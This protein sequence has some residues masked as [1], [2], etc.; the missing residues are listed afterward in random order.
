MLCRAPTVGG[1]T[2][3]APGPI[4]DSVSVVIFFICGCL[5]VAFMA[6]LFYDFLTIYDV[7]AFRQVLCGRAVAGV[8]GLSNLHS[9]EVEDS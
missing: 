8:A 1:V 9:A 6:V 4:S 3:L 2:E 5:Y 7:N